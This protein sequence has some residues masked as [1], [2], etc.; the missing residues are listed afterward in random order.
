[1]KIELQEKSI[2]LLPENN[3]EIECLNKLHQH[4]ID[5]LQFQDSWNNT[6]YLQLN[7][8]IHPWDK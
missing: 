8:P 4:G 1:M 5:K 6:G 3:W 7:F 2:R